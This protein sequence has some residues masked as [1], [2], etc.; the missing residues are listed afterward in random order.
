[1][2]RNGLVRVDE[3]KSA[4]GRR[5]I[6]LPKFAVE[7]RRKRRGLHY[8]GAPKLQF[9]SQFGLAIRGVY[10]AFSL[11]R[12]GVEIASQAEYA[13]SIP[14]I[15]STASCGNTVEGQ[16]ARWPATPP[17][18]R[19]RLVRGAITPAQMRERAVALRRGGWLFIAPPAVA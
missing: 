17:V 12:S 13:G 7:M 14:V 18:P 16:I 10:Q 4:A 3:T 1:M 6:P 8:L 2:D 15:G 11:T 9:A 5:T 19:L